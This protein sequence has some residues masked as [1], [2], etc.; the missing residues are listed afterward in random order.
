MKCANKSPTEEC[1]APLTH[2]EGPGGGTRSR[3][4]NENRRV[5]ISVAFTRSCESAKRTSASCVRETVTPEPKEPQV[6]DEPLGP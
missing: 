3:G 2:G 4:G 5:C 1:G 6:R